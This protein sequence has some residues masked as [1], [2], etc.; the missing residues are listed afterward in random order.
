M[1][2][3]NLEVLFNI[4]KGEEAKEIQITLED[5]QVEQLYHVFVHILLRI[6]QPRCI[7]KTL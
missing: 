1:Y 3:H 2:Q 4:L 7:I 5:A 6:Y